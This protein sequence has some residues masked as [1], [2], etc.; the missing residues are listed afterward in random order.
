MER[1]GIDTTI[2]MQIAGHKSAHMWKQYNRV[3]ESDLVAAALNS[4]LSRTVITPAGSV[5][6]VKTAC[7]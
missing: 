6:S 3:A 7:G 2:A 5:E 4:Y 1:A